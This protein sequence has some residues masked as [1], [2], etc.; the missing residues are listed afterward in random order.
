MNQYINSARDVV[1]TQTTNVQTFKSGEKGYLGNILGGE[2]FRFNDRLHRRRFSIPKNLPDVPLIKMY[3]G[4][5]G[6]F[7]RSAIEMGT[8]GIVIEAVGA[9]NVN[10]EMYAAIK[11]ALDHKIPVVIT[12]SVTHGGVFPAYGDVG[13]GAMLQKEGA[14]L[15]RQLKGPKARLLLMLAIPEVGIDRDRLAKLF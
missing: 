10:K 14:I 15:S 3:P 6:R 13:G 1:K 11:E 8:E 4:S 7:V 2:V 12:S 5:D 9:G